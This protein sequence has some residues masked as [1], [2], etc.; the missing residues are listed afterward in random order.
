M[1]VVSDTSAITSLIQIRREELLSKLFSRVLIPTAVRNELLKFHPS[2]PDFVEEAAVQDH[3]LL[4][5]LCEKIDIGEGEAIVLA[6]ERSA[7]FILVDD[8]AARK[9]AIKRGLSVIGLVGILVVAKRK[10]LIASLEQ[11]LNELEKTAGFRVSNGLKR[12]TLRSVG[13]E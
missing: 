7:D 5:E 12:S 6:H 8:L 10:K 4:R 3:V 13:E 9:I 2:L 1:T 11:V